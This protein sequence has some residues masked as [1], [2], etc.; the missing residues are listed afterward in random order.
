MFTASVDV[1]A[2]DVLCVAAPDVAVLAR[3]IAVF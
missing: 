2:I 1:F 3:D